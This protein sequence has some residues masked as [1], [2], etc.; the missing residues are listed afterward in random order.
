MPSGTMPCIFIA[1]PC[2][3]AGAFLIKSGEE[4]AAGKGGSWGAIAATTLALASFGQGG[5]GMLAA[6][7]M[8]KVMNDKSEELAK[9][10]PEHKPVEDLTKAEEAYKL[11]YKEVAEWSR[12]P[13]FY[14]KILQF[15]T[16]INML[17]FFILNWRSEDCF[18]EFSLTSKVSDSYADGGLNGKAYNI[19]Q[20]LGWVVVLMFVLACIL[21]KIV[22]SYVAGET[23]RQMAADGSNTKMEVKEAP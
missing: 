2:V 21:L 14:K 4:D 16:G 7:Y 12:I 3:L 8:T 17:A 22:L 15:G 1:A 5:A 23:K 18:M 10:R 13:T 20:P 19:V 6:Y 11:K 9:P